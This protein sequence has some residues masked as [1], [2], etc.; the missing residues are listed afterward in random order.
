MHGISVALAVTWLSHSSQYI[1]YPGVIGCSLNCH[2]FLDPLTQEDGLMMM[3]VR[4]VHVDLNKRGQKKVTT[5]T[6]Q[7]KKKTPTKRAPRPFS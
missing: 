4:L 6:L 1:L 5:Y 7:R 3:M 2:R